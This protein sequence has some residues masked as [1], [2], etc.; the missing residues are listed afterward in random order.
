MRKQIIVNISISLVTTTLCVIFLF[1][2]FTR[3]VK[4]SSVKEDLQYYTNLDWDDADINDVPS[5]RN[6]IL[7]FNVRGADSVYTT[8]INSQGFR[9]YEYGIEKPENSIRIAAVG[10]S[11]TYG[12]G[13]NLEDTYVKQLERMLNERSDRK[14]EVLNFGANGA[15]T[16]NELEL[17]QRKVLLYKPDIIMLQIDPNDAEVIHQIKKV[18]AF[19]NGFILKLKGSSLEIGQWLKQKLEFYK[20][21]RYRKQM[22]FDDEYNNIVTP[23]NAIRD[24]CKENNI[25]LIVLS[26]DSPYSIRY[27]DRVLQ[28]VAAQGIPLLDLSNTKFGKLSYEQK[29]INPKL[30]RNGYPLDSHPSKYGSKIIADEIAVFFENMNILRPGISRLTPA[31]NVEYR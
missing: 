31:I 1:L 20:Y 8:K 2:F 9:D 6:T 11:V 29:Y 3:M 13:V 10:D 17:I 12:V 22:T 24:T 26:Y 7:S 23:L 25:R 30:G 5:R 27:Y 4:S 14:V 16:I 28:Y 21:Y 18:D 19:L 15:S